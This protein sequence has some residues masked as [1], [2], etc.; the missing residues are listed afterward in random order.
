MIISLLCIKL[1]MVK[2]PYAPAVFT[3]QEIFLVL[4]SVRG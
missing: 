4:I 2:G 1:H 3:L